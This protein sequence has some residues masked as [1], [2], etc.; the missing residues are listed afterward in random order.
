MIHGL[1]HFGATGTPVPPATDPELDG[2]KASAVAL[3]LTVIGFLRQMREKKV[4]RS[5]RCTETA[6]WGLMPKIAL[7]PLQSVLLGAFGKVTVTC[8]AEGGCPSYLVLPG[9]KLR[10]L[11][12]CRTGSL[13][14]VRRL[15]WVAGD[16]CCH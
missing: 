8:A 4:G 13:P 11:N 6:A 15:A 2:L 10:L 16:A 9:D 14:D 3:E 7:L 5:L 1:T 12:C